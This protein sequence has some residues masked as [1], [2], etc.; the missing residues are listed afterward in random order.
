MK[1]NHRYFSNA[2]NTRVRPWARW[3]I[4]YSANV[5]MITECDLGSFSRQAR[6]VWQ[7]D[8]YFINEFGAGK[9]IQIGDSPQNNWRKG[10]F[11]INESAHG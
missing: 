5:Q 10:Q 4:G 3:Q 6:L 7:S 2:I 8:N 11:V 9:P 1:C